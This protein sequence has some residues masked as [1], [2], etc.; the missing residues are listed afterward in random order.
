MPRAN[1][2]D[3]STGQSVWFSQL[4]DTA[5]PGAIVCLPYAGMGSAA[6][7]GW[8]NS[9]F[10]AA[11]IFAAQLPGR[12]GRLH[13]PPIDNAVEL[14]GHLADAVSGSPLADRPLTLLGCS[15]GGVVAYELACQLRL[16]GR[17]IQHL[18]VAA[19]R[20]PSALS[21]TDPVASLPDQDMISKLQD[22]YDA[23][24]PEIGNNPDILE[25]VLPAIRADMHVY[26][27]YAYRDAEPLACP[28]TAI[29][30]SDD[31][32]VSINDLH[33]WQKETSAKFSCRQ[34]AGNHFFVNNQFATVLRYL[35]RQI[36]PR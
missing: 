23:I 34:F 15:F 21:V 9:K 27:T 8:R 13:D 4:T 24:P 33:G 30:G 31:R 11:D 2:S 3:S 29:G 17:N 18:V 14:A 32:M 19:C 12:D 10:D 20:P 1:S 5:A 26:E 36:G 25:L 16:R 22:W 35:Q 7:S 28:I 6:F